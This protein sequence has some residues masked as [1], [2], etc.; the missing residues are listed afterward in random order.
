MT[1]LAILILAAGRSSRMRGADKLLQE[2]DGTPVLLVMA[3]RALATGTEVLIAIP[4]RDHPRA[5]VI[6]PLPVGPVG[7]PD[8]GLG[9]S[10]SIRA[11]IAALPNGTEAVMILPADMPEITGSDLEAM[12]A[13]YEPGSVLR[14]TSADGRAGHPVIFP[15]DCFDDLTSLTG[16][17]GARDVI[18]ANRDRLHLIA[19]PDDHALTDLDTPEDW[20]AW[21]A[22]RQGV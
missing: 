9:M 8:A 15:A 5:K 6:A 17:R 16:D 18:A 10:A 19:L 7:V 21:R 13:A 3:R 20:Q 1:R 14:A 11:G 12:I 4:S 22:A 2:V